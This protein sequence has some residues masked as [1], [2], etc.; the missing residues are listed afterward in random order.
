MFSRVC[1]GTCLTFARHCC[2]QR[3]RNKSCRMQRQTGI[4]VFTTK[5]VII[6]K[7]L[8]CVL[9]TGYC[10]LPLQTA[11]ISCEGR[12]PITSI[13]VVL[14]YVIVYL[15]AIDEYLSIIYRYEDSRV[16]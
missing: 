13:C 5:S 1:T 10:I 7:K 9:T 12:K 8:R 16:S 2:N 3:N 6:Y 14:S 4:S 11:V 15:D